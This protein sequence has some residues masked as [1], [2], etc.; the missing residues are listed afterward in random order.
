MRFALL[1]FG[2]YLVISLV[3]YWPLWPGSTHMTVGG[4][5]CG[6]V[7]QEMWFLKWTPWALVHGHNPFFTNWMDVPRGAN[8]ASNTTMPLLA[9]V[10]APLTWLWGPVAS[11]NLLM[12]LSFPL[13]AITCLYAV[14]KMM[15]SN[16][17][18][19]VAGFMYGFSPYMA[20]QGL[21]HV[22]LVFVPIPPLIFYALYRI[23]VVQ[24]GSARRWGLILAALVIC[25]FFISQEV[26]VLTIIVA[27]FAVVILSL[28][29]RHMIERDRVHYV[30]QSGLYAVVATVVILAYP[31]YCQLFGPQAVHGAAHGTTHSPFKLDLL[32]TVVPDQLQ[33][34]HPGFLTRLGNGFMGTDL[35]ENG[36]YLGLP[37]VVVLGLIVWT[38]RRNRWVLYIGAVLVVTEVLS[39]GRWFMVANHTIR[40]P[41]PWA[42][43]AKIPI[44]ETI[45]A[46]RFAL[47]ASFFMVLL[48]AAGVVQWIRWVDQAPRARRRDRRRVVNW[49]LSALAVASFAVYLPR[50]PIMT[51]PMPS[52]PSFFTTADDLQIPAGSVVLPFPV[53]ASPYSIA[54]YW[55]IRADFRWKMIGGEAIILTPR[56]HVTGQPAATSPT[57]VTQYLLHLSG[58]RTRLPTFNTALIERMREFLFLNQ[59]GTV[60]LDPLAP[61]ANKALS[62]FIAAFGPPQTEGGMDVWFHVQALARKTAAAAPQG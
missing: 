26:A 18:A 47:L 32:G 54:M 45:L 27:F 20:S 9:L 31:V 44:F 40:V 12:W 10:T 50:L 30:V 35:T 41:M 58:A 8:L 21:G 33:A 49:A 43:L 53:S 39:M 19:L 16:V 22:F 36:S 11:Y 4:C 55:Q 1:A 5:A 2:I 61:N 17:A 24:E 6:D 34:I 51:V 23:L 15:H 14:R 56:G 46:S 42:A 25:Q 60:V 37:L 52:V 59:V 38:M 57:A 29:N 28:A 7:M 3:V 48:V 62:L 13:S